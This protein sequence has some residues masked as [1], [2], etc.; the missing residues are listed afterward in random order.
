MT[1]EDLLIHKSRFEEKI[2]LQR[3]EQG[4]NVRT[5]SEEEYQTKIERLNKIKLPGHRMVPQDYTLMK[6]YDI[7]EVEKDGQI[8]Q[9]LVK[10]N[11]KDGTRKR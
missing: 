3:E 5:F 7:L 2:S 1:M 8:I 4:K 10:F 6:N 9:R 11:V